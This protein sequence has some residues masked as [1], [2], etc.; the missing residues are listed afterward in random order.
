M[1]CGGIFISPKKKEYPPPPQT[2]FPGKYV[3]RNL[4]KINVK[5]EHVFLHK[6]AS[7]DF[8]SQAH[9]LSRKGKKDDTKVI[10]ACFECLCLRGD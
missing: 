4:S 8:E 3:F 2:L 7:E 5:K 10:M 6:I 1:A 9:L